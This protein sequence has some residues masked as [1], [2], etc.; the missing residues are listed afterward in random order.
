MIQMSGVII[1]LGYILGLLFTAIPWGG[2]WIVVL[3]IAIAIIFRIQYLK[4]RKITHKQLENTESKTKTIPIARQTLIQPRVW[5][6]AG[7]V[8]LLAT[9]YFQWRIPQ[10]GTKDISIFVPSENN[11]QE[12]LV[13][14]RGEVE[15]SPRLTRSQRGQFWLEATQLDEVKNDKGPAD[16]PKGVTGKLYVTVPILQ[17]TGLYPGQQIAVTGSLYK[18]K[19]ASNP[20]AFDFQKFLKQ[21]GSFAGLSGRQINIIDTDEKRQWGWWQIRE[22]IVRSQV[23]WLGIPE[24]PLVSAMVLGSK[25]VD[26]PYD[27]RDLFVQAGLAHALAASGFQT[28]LILG[29]ILQL[30]RRTKKLTQFIL[31]FLALIIF[32][33]LTG[34]QPAVLRAVIMGAA[35]L[36]GL[37]LDR[38]VQQLGSLLLAA[39]LLLIFNP[40]WIW[41]LGFQLSFL[42]TLGLIV[43]ASPIVQRLAW[44]PPAIASLVAVPLAATIWTLPLQLFVFGVVP[45]YSLFLNIITTPLIS[46]IS[47]GGIISAIAALIWPTAGSALAGVLHYPTDWLIKLVEFFSNLPGNSVALGSISAWQLLA[48]YA[49]IILTWLLHWWRKRWWFASLIAFGIV[50]VPVWHSANTLFRI[51]LLE[52]DAEPVLVVQDRGKVTLINSGEEGTGRFTILPFLQQQ[53]VN[54]IDWAIASNFQS[55]DESDAWLE[56]L[57]Y[58]P[59]KT[60]YTYSIKTENPI[61][62]QAIQQALQKQQGIY[63]A[64]AIGQTINTGAVVAQL[65]NDQPLLQ[66]QILGQSWLIVGNAKSQEIL[67]TVKTVGLS[68]P[69]VLWCTPESLKDLVIALKPQVAIAA[70]SNLDSK[71]L[72][73]LSKSQTKIFFTGRD[74]AIQWTPNGQFETFI[75]STENKSSVL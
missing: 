35:A 33:S 10:P 61:T 75:Q 37:V 1:C 44:L 55:N 12:Q 48:I 5:I 9:V 68:S 31:G 21:E 40:L 69:Q 65:V 41:D 8:G 73:D 56:L 13:I 17:A 67:K 22:R 64:L 26:L 6:A 36:I 14:V 3:G 16:V 7:L 59:I 28:S 25:A 30:T 71:T 38:K 52:A 47:I 63:Q 72:A 60:F 34:F 32:L 27:I 20:G 58:L 53:G 51:T 46:V 23:R 62:D 29:V 24:G 45:A 54:K 15:S 39:T 70:S 74:G 43:S 18:P 66:L 11:N 50:I 57:Q 4:S 42:A 2:V 19:A 49:L